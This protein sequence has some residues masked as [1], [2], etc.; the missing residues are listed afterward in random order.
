MKKTFFNTFVVMALALMTVPQASL[1]QE[2]DID[3]LLEGADDLEEAEDAQESADEGAPADAA[4]EPADAADGDAA[5]GADQPED[6]ETIFVIQRKP[7]L[8]G[9]AF[10]LSP[11]YVQTINSRFINHSGFIFSGVYH[12]KKT[13]LLKSRGEPVGIRY[14]FDSGAHS[15]RAFGTRNGEVL[16]A[17]VVGYC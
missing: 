17:D 12:L 5:A 2:D 13:L 9:G 15:K 8:V 11:Q 6:V 14:G 1:A 16:R 10:E 3:A 4:D 7:I